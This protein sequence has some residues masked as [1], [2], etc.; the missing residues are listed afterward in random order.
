MLAKNEERVTGFKY[1]GIGERAARDRIAVHARA[2]LA[3]GVFDDPGGAEH[4]NKPHVDGGHPTVG[5]ADQEPAR[6]PFPRT[7]PPPPLGPT[8]DDFVDPAE[9]RMRR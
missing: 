3:A 5:H 7:R 2:V 6:T 9:P 1:V 4:A 8:G